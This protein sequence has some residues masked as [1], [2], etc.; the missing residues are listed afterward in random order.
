MR[1]LR[2]LRVSAGGVAEGSGTPPR[3]SRRI[4]GSSVGGRTRARRASKLPRRVSRAQRRALQTC[5][6]CPRCSRRMRGER[7]CASVLSPTAANRGATWQCTNVGRQSRGSTAPGTPPPTTPPPACTST[8]TR[9]PITSRQLT[10]PSTTIPSTPTPRATR[11]TSRGR[12]G[13]LRGSRGLG[14]TRGLCL[15]G[16][17]ADTTTTLL[18]RVRGTRREPATA[19][20]LTPI[21]C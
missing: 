17:T 13:R 4:S 14:H 15:R 8:V 7:R 10:S 9:M 20:A 1:P 18:A 21:L 19:S 11:T 6:R 2:S 16:T 12:A 5:T 3:H